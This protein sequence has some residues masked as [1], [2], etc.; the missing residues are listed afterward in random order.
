MTATERPPAP[1]VEAWAEPATITQFLHV[2]AGDVLVFQEGDGVV[3]KVV[4]SSEHGLT[5]FLQQTQEIVFADDPLRSRSFPVWDHVHRRY[6]VDWDSNARCD[7]WRIRLGKLTGEM[8]E[9]MPAWWA[10]MVGPLE[11]LAWLGHAV[12]LAP[13]PFDHGTLTG[14]GDTNGPDRPAMELVLLTWEPRP[15]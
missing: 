1:P 11:W 14:Y 13:P 2:S 15:T 12:S 3:E 10:P 4:L 7:A 8:F 9:T 6:D 5:M